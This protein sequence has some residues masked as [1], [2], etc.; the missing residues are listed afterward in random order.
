MTI[1]PIRIFS[2]IASSLSYLEL[3][4]IF[5]FFSSFLGIKESRRLSRLM[6]GPGDKEVPDAGVFKS[7][8]KPGKTPK[9][10]GKTPENPA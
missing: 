1:T 5:H 6:S 3:L 2:T 9:N 10:P 7:G 4:I 8:D